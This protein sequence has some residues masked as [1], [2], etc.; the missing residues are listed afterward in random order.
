MA[1]N[2]TRLVSS[3]NYQAYTLRRGG[4]QKIE[5][6]EG[7]VDTMDWDFIEEEEIVK[8]HKTS[9]ENCISALQHA[10]TSV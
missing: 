4:F 7:D 5:E 9:S 6:R 2:Q 3:E 8:L 1:E 10:H